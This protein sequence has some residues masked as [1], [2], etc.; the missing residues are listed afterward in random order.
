MPSVTSK[1]AMN[2]MSKK[3]SFEKNHLPLI[4]VHVDQLALERGR[5]KI[6]G[7]RWGRG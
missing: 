6:F 7:D 2:N 1:A 4:H 5:G 3:K